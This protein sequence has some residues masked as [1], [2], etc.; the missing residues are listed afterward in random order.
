MVKDMRKR[1]RKCILIGAAFE[2]R[3]KRMRT[4]ISFLPEIR[5]TRLHKIFYYVDIS[6]L[7]FGIRL[8]AIHVRSGYEYL[9]EEIV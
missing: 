1:T 2:C 7:C 4:V 5:F 6:V 3:A 8:W 9:I